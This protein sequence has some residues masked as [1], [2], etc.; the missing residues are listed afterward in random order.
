MAGIYPALKRAIDFLA[1]ALGLVLLWPVFALVALA[2]LL[3]DGKPVFFRQERVGKNGKAFRIFKFR[4]MFPD[5]ESG[6]PLTSEDDP[7]ITRAGRFLRRWSLDELPQL[8]NVLLGHMSLVGPRPTLPY[9]TERYDAR[10]RMRLLVR[11]GITGLAQVKGRNSLSWPERIE[12]DLQY[13]EKMSL[14]FDFRI[15]FMSV[16]ALIRKKAIYKPPEEWE[17]DPIAKKEA[18]P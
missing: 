9:Q 8:I 11:P 6:G 15:I 10:Q 17:K 16:P 18:R 7:R 12:L 13:I 1:A 3:D 4:T 2:I 5:A 14:R